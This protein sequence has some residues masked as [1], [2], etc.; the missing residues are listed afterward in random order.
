MHTNKQIKN[1]NKSAQSNGS[2]MI[3]PSKRHMENDGSLIPKKKRKSN[4]APPYDINN[5]N[6]NNNNNSNNNNDDM[7]IEDDDC[8]N[9]ESIKPQYHL[10]QSASPPKKNNKISSLHPTVTILSSYDDNDINIT[11]NGNNSLLRSKIIKEQSINL[12]VNNNNNNNEEKQRKPIFSMTIQKKK[13]NLGNK[14]NQ[15]LTFMN[16]SIDNNEN[17]KINNS[18]NKENIS[19]QNNSTDTNDI[20]DTNETQLVY[21]FCHYIFLS[22]YTLIFI[23]IYLFHNNAFSQK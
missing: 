18:D 10:T 23:L 8:N 7:D 21:E 11:K 16:C 2:T 20:T 22:N 14:K 15:L 1:K 3:F 17:N 12:N 5:N 19:S 6:N 9:N 13:T 4:T